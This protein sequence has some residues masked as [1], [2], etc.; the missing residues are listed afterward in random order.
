MLDFLSIFTYIN[1]PCVL[2]DTLW[3]ILGFF[4]PFSYSCYTYFNTPTTSTNFHHHAC[5]FCQANTNAHWG[6]VKPSLSPRSQFSLP[7]VS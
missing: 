3:F 7:S 5:T 2:S 1:G 6:H 4:F